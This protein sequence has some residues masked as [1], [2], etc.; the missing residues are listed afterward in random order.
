MHIIAIS[1]F[2]LNFKTIEEFLCLYMIVKFADV[3]CIR[4]SL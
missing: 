1:L 2:Q 3:S 4:Y